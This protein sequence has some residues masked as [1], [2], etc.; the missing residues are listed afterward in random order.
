MVRHVLKLTEY[1][2]P[3]SGAWHALDCT[4][5]GQCSDAWY[6]LPRMLNISVTD[7]IKMLVSKYHA[8]GLDFSPSK[9]TLFFSF[10]KHE[11]CHRFVLDMNREA[12][13]R[14][15]YIE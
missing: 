15:F 1:Q 8:S 5:V 10:E 6:F 3:G 7:Y 14:K 9:G 4:N 11:D 2:S 13:N 12:R